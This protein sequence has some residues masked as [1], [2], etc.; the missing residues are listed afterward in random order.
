MAGTDPAFRAVVLQCWECGIECWLGVS[1]YVAAYV[2]ARSS[3]AG[4]CDRKP[5]CVDRTR[6][7]PG[8]DALRRLVVRHAHSPVRAALGTTTAVP[9]RKRR[10]H[11][12]L[13]ALSATQEPGGGGGSLRR[14]G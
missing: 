8:R 7:Q 5:L 1:D 4:S 12:S 6:V 14:R 2:F 10:V 3:Q 13:P 11:C 9:D